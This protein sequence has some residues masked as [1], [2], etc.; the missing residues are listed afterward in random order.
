MIIGRYI[1]RTIHLGTLVALL[2]LVS[3]GLFFVFVSELDD[4]GQGKYDLPQILWFIVLSIPGK[5]VEFMPLAVLL[6]SI[7]SLGTLA[8][9]SEK[10]RCRLRVF[11]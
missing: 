1:V 9:N 10:S 8:S 2:G 11:R 5:V 4:L 7:L 3:L 6:G